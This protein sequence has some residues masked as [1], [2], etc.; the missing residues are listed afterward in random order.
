LKAEVLRIYDEAC[1]EAPRINAQEA[2]WVS[3]TGEM[4][5]ALDAQKRVRACPVG[6]L[7]SY[8]LSFIPWGLGGMEESTNMGTFEE[9]AVKM[10]KRKGVGTDGLTGASS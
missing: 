7:S 4:Q 3:I 5:Q 9:V 10:G 6:G 1:R 2:M 8:E